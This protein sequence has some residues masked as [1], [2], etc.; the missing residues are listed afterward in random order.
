M[1]KKKRNKN[2]QNRNRRKR[3]RNRKKTIIFCQYTKFK[4]IKTINGI[5]YQYMA[6]T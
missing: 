3:S 2:K 1:R 6:A 5:I 4:N